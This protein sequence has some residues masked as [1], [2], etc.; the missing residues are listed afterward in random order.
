MLSTYLVCAKH[1]ISVCLAPSG[2]S[3]QYRICALRTWTFN[4]FCNADELLHL[5]MS[6]NGEP[7]KYAAAQGFT[8]YL[9]ESGS[10]TASGS[11]DNPG[12]QVG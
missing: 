3:M 8:V 9:R 1:I 7:H 2:S 12:E 4:F 10:G 6:R 5:Y 11:S